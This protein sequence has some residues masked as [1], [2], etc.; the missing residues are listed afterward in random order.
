MHLPIRRA[1]AKAT[2]NG[3]NPSLI[4]SEFIR[5]RA[6]SSEVHCWDQPTSSVGWVQ[7]EPKASKRA[8]KHN[9]SPFTAGDGNQSTVT[10]W[11]LTRNRGGQV[12]FLMNCFC[13]GKAPCPNKRKPAVM[14]TK[15][16]VCIYM[17]KLMC[18]WGSKK[19]GCLTAPLRFL[20]LPHALLPLFA[21]ASVSV[22]DCHVCVHNA[23]ICSLPPHECAWEKG[24][25]RRGKVLWGSACT[26][27]ERTERKRERHTKREW[28]QQRESL[29]RKREIGRMR[30]F[31]RS[32]VSEFQ[33]SYIV[34]SQQQASSAA[35]NTHRVL[36]TTT[37]WPLYYTTVNTS[38][39]SSSYWN[40]TAKKTLNKIQAN[41]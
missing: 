1:P 11:Q 32:L 33:G 38:N 28:N 21:L 39:S 29:K 3:T 37:G 24:I 34:V 6:T 14:A 15:P 22:T 25:G 9:P 18:M 17:W 2:Y 4:A 36:C 26:C 13:M 7:K 23:G 20:I 16:C 5:D 31:L 27:Q 30:T 12:C 41:T 40:K 19:R 35:Y 10:G 8:G